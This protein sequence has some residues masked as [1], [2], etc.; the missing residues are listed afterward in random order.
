MNYPDDQIE[1]VEL[2]E[3]ELGTVAAGLKY[4][5]SGSILYGGNKPNN[6]ESIIIEIGLDE[7]IFENRRYQY[8][9]K[10]HAWVS[11]GIDFPQ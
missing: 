7:D 10:T 3:E 9:A 5:V 11:V 2:A 8:F 6:R 4:K 1:G